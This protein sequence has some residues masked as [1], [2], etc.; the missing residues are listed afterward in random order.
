[1]RGLSESEIL[2]NEVWQSSWPTIEL[3][4]SSLMKPASASLSL[5]ERTELTYKR[6]KA[7]ANAHDL[8]IKDVAYIT[9]RFWKLHTDLLGAMDGGATTLVS[10]QYNLFIGTVAPFAASRPD[11]LPILQRA[12]K[13]DVSAQ[14]MLTEVGHGLDAR[15][16]ETTATLLPNGGFELHSPSPAA[17]KCMPPSTPRSGL[18]VVAVVI[19][20]LMVDGEDRGV[21]PFLVS[22][23]DGTQMCKGVVSK[24]LPPRTGANPVDHALTYFN[25]V[26]LPSSALLGSLAKPQSERDDFLSTIHRVSAGTLLLSSGCIPLLKTAIYNASQFSFQR[27]ILGHDGNSMP[28]MKF[29]TQHLPILHAIAQVHVLQ[30]FLIQAATGFRNPKAD[31]RVRHAIATVFKAVAL[32]HFGKSIK[33][34]N[35]GCGWQGYY[36]HNQTLQAELE[37]RA[38]GTAEGDIRVLAIRLASE[39]LIGRYQVP[40]PR[41]PTSLIAQHEMGLFAEAQQ[42]LKELGGIHRSDEFNRNILPL[43]LPL[44]EAIGY[45]MAVEAAIDVNIDPRL[46]ALYESGIVKED[47]AWF[48]EQGGLTRQEQ[49]EMEAL[50]ADAVL[51]DLAQLVQDTGAQPYSTAPMASRSAWGGLWRDWRAL[52]G[53]AVLI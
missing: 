38:V 5:D 4:Q 28:V 19:A 32:H 8:T 26:R 50:A 35:E 37:F 11:L 9:P 51:P 34:L 23:T 14:F 25:N 40:P 31:P 48:A 42:T 18:P 1:M 24:V 43:A 16:L 7:L 10:I 13:F 44:V 30:A 12:L 17:A 39:L 6:A 33:T 45:R 53:R 52:R 22:L 2:Y 15:N 36:E 20:R 27:M 49:R 47:P 29:R 41:D 3:A 21:R 46:L